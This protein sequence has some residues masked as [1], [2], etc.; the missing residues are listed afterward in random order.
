MVGKGSVWKES[1]GV[2]GWCC[3]EAGCVWAGEGFGVGWVIVVG[4]AEGVV[5]GVVVVVCISVI[6]G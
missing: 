4:G 2:A 1:E 5:D 3:V 6:E